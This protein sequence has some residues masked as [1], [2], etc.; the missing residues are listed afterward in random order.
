MIAMDL[1]LPGSGAGRT[2]IDATVSRRGW[3]A[4]SV[5]W[6]R[7]R[8]GRQVG[9]DLGVVGRALAL[10]RRRGGDAA[11]EGVLEA[12]GGALD[13]GAEGGRL[14]FAPTVP[15]E[16]LGDQIA[17]DREAVVRRLGEGA[18]AAD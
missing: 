3:R 18:L 8:L 17:V 1:S 12:G 16:F 15:G 11:V 2:T 14:R 7:S 5:R 10:L 9:E 6:G 4:S 13:Q